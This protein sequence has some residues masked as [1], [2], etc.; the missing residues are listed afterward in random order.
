VRELEQIAITL[1]VDRPEGGDI[2]QFLTT[3]KVALAD[4]AGEDAV[5]RAMKTNEDDTVAAYEQALSNSNADASLRPL[6]EKALADERRHRAWMDT[7]A[8]S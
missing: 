6:F 8:S 3:G 7:T 4:L 1:G 5:L 2:K